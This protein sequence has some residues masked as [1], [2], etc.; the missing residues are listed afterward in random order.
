MDAIVRPFTGQGEQPERVERPTREEAEAAV[1][2]LIAYSGDNPRREGL[3]DTPERVT[4]AYGELFRGYSECP[5]EALSRTF[6]E[7]GGYD[8][9]V[10]IR[11]IEFFSHCEHHIL[12]FVGKAHVAYYPEGRVVGLSKLAR[13]VDIFARRLQTQENLT[14]QIAAAIEQVLKPRGV[15]VMI[16]AEHMCMSLRGISKVGA[17][18]VTSQFSG[19]FRE[20]SQERARFLSLVRDR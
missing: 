11:D 20:D 7:V 18:T 14:A 9:V 13:V 5:V 10:L 16:E 8:D 4:R 1:R 12:P 6:E 2:T 3:L 15:A 17:S 19:M